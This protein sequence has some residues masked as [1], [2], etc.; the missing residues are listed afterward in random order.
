MR[1]ISSGTGILRPDFCAALSQSKLNFRCIV[2]H[3]FVLPWPCQLV[4]VPP[5]CGA[6]GT[7]PK[8]LN[9]MWTIASK[10]TKLNPKSMQSN[11]RAPTQGQ[12]HPQKNVLECLVSAKAPC[13]LGGTKQDRWVVGRLF[14]VCEHLKIDTPGC[15]LDHKFNLII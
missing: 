10:S 11:H 14:V 1:C 13:A 7:A 2:H 5:V 6:S 9:L 12:C 3:N 4:S 15:H 8:A